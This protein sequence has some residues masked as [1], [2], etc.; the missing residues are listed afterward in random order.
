M[1][2]PLTLP[3]SLR[4]FSLYNQRNTKPPHPTLF[5]PPAM[6]ARR[7]RIVC[8]SFALSLS[9]YTFVFFV[10]SPF[11]SRFSHLSLL[12]QR[13]YPNINPPPILASPFPFTLLPA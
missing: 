12:L 1:V 10:G 2:L 6:S 8:P 11:L 13:Q 7:I 3:L 9:S 4:V 5:S